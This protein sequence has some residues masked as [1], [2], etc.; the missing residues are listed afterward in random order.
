MIAIIGNYI[1]DDTIKL[2][3]SILN[4]PLCYLNRDIV[5]HFKDRTLYETGK[6]VGININ[7]KTITILRNDNTCE[8]GCAINCYNK[9]YY[10]RGTL[11]FDVNEED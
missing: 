7:D 2:W 1:D 3:S 9:I 10:N 11:I 8:F 5:L 6:I 4:N